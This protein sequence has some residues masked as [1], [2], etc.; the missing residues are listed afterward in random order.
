MRGLRKELFACVVLVS[1]AST[2]GA[3]PYSYA[4][5]IAPTGEYK[6]GLPV[7]AWMLYPSIFVGAT[8]DT[9][10]DQTASGPQRNSGTSLR[11]SPR[12][13]GNYDGGIH[14]TSAYGIVD[15]R[16]FDANNVAASAGAFAHLRSDAGS[17]I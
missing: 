15:A 4:Q 5:E 10:F 9:N 6:P 3:V 16:F 11:V 14:K 2:I 1:M 12:F 8:Y 17:H 13:T 7:G